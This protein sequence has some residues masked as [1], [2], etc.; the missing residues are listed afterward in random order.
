M[1]DETKTETP[2]TKHE[3]EQ[4]VASFEALVEELRAE[5]FGRIAEDF[6]Q[7]RI[8]LEDLIGEDDARAD[9]PN[10][11]AR[12][13][14]AVEALFAEPKP[15][16]MGMLAEALAEFV[17]D[18][19]F[20]FLVAQA[21]GGKKEDGHLHDPSAPNI[22]SIPETPAEATEL[23]DEMLMK[24]LRLLTAEYNKRAARTP[25]TA[26]SAPDVG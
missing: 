2:E 11:R 5:T 26:P 8:E 22:A 24:A 1:S 13:V 12:L 15:S 25:P 16:P 20:Q 3:T 6:V 18:P 9:L 23:T 10:E 17:A 21:L 19:K 14:H 7:H 4:R